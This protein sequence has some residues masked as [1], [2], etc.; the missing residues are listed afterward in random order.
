MSLSL[1]R[2]AVF[3]GATLALFMGAAQAQTPAGDTLAKIRQTGTLVIGNGGAYPPFEFVE[4]G[5]L[6][7]FDIDLGNELGRRMGV[8]V[9]WKVTDFSG[10]MASLTSGRVD[11]LAT[12]FTSTPERAARI[13]FSSSYYK[14]G[15]A[16]AYVETA[17]VTQP[18]DLKGKIVGVQSG[19]PGDKFVRDKYG[20][21]VKDQRIYS[22]FHLALRDL[23][24][25]RT[26]VV[27]NSLPVL[28]YNLARHQNPKVKIKVTEAWDARD[29]GIN[30]RL[31]DQP[32]LAEINTHLAAMHS[33]GFLK[34]LNAK[35]FGEQ[36]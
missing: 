14:T 6:A 2:K 27:V 21:T 11:I 12:A 20:D 34:Q 32:L 17:P 29:L 25:G 1:I 13:A 8:K 23:E 3:C 36:P 10:L 24:L 18:D 15:I 7:G 5:K 4:N 35:W 28:R 33:D 19:T 26:Q 16:A 22:E 31:T 30:T 9:D